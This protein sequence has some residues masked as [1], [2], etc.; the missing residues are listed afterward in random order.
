MTSE[1]KKIIICMPIVLTVWFSFLYWL[2]TISPWV[3]GTALGVVFML[4][5]FMG[6]AD[7]DD[8]VE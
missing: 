7:G 8:S 2:S 3:V 1:D 6:M 5:M 4:A